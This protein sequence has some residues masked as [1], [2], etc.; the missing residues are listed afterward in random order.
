MF[1]TMLIPGVYQGVPGQMLSDEQLEGRITL[2]RL[3]RITQQTHRFSTW[4]K[5]DE[6]IEAC[7]YVYKFA[8]G[9]PEK[10]FLTLA[11]QPGTGKTHL[12]L[13]CAWSWLETARQ[14]TR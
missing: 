11:G 10:N 1:W 3:P 7:D 8:C 14:S 9:I 5:R 13:A 12:A 2:S 4:Q 6:L